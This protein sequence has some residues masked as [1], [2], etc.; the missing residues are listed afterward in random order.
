M[1]VPPLHQLDAVMADVDA[2]D[3]VPPW[4]EPVDADPVDEPRWTTIIFAAAVALCAVPAFLTYCGS[5]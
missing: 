4:L 5:L 2:D 3:L 1:S